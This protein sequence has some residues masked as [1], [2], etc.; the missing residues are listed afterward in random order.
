MS[1]YYNYY[2][3]YEWDGKIYPLGPYNSFGQ[4]CDVISKS[5]SFASDLHE[6]FYNVSG[7]QISD[8]LRKNFEYE[9]YKGDKVVEVKYLPLDELP[10]GSFI[11]K[12][13]FL[14]DDV[15]RYE[16]GADKWDIFYDNLTPEMYAAMLQNELILGKPAPK[17]DCEGYE[18][19][20]HS[21]S[22]YMF[23]AYPDYDSKEYEAEILRCAIESLYSYRYM[24]DDNKEVVI[25][26]TEG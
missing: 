21:A 25:L 26:E 9:D 19:E 24:N 2:I 18:I 15:K 5:R 11:K 23:Y 13:Y 1:Y 6:C 4:L 16:D 10:S 3:G 22:E 12:G 14:I 17:K 8:E 20:V 7:D